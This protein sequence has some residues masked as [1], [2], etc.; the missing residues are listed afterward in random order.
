MMTTHP[1]LQSLLR[2]TKVFNFK[3]LKTIPK[4][5]EIIYKKMLKD[6]LVKYISA[7]K[8]QEVLKKVLY[9]Q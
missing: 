6:I 9:R 3:Q 2:P 7:E 5:K 4:I 8:G 1:I